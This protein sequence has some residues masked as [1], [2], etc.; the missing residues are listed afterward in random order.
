MSLLDAIPGVRWVEFGVVAIAVASAASV[1]LVQHEQILA[2]KTALAQ[3][4]AG[5]AAD[6]AAMASA[7]ASASEAA[8]TEEQR[9]AA[10]I[11]ETSNEAIRQASH[12]RDDAVTAADAA[13]RL[14]QRAAAVAAGCSRTA[15]DPAAAAGS[16]PAPDPGPVLA[17]VLGRLGDAAGQ[18]AVAAD[19]ARIAGQACTASYEALT[20]VAGASAVP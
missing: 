16:A 10:A 2:G 20:P 1:M 12:A 9:R 4:Q 11:T 17:D 19:G 5:R 14:R 3:E 18:L 7:A 13:G 6:R 8:R 15:G